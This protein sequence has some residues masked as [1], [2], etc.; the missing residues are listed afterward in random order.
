VQ[1]LKGFQRVA[2]KAGETKNISFT[3]KSD[4]F[5]YFDIAKHAWLTPAGQ[6]EIALGQSS[7]DNG[8]AQTIT[9][10]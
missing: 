4:S 1:E 8:P 9:I 5:A 7:R 6:Y 10:K 2:L 3:L